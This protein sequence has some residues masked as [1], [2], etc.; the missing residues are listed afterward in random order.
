MFDWCLICWIGL[1]LLYPLAYNLY[2]VGLVLIE[3]GMIS[4]KIWWCSSTAEKFCQGEKIINFQNKCIVLSIFC[5]EIENCR[6]NFTK[7]WT[8]VELL[9]N[10]TVSTYLDIF[11][12]VSPLEKTFLRIKC[13]SSFLVLKST[14]IATWS[15]KWVHTYLY[16]WL[17][18]FRSHVKLPLL[19]T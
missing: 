5:T 3:R 8:R 12:Q 2:W 18:S 15:R 9:P 7:I 6:C 1:W 17:T 13:K 10:F 19:V 16:F 11:L 4:K 14:L